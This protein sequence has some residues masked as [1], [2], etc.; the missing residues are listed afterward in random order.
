MMLI[1][2]AFTIT[3]ALS[4]SQ[5]TFAAQDDNLKSGD[6]PAANTALN[7]K[8]ANT[9]DDESLTPILLKKDSNVAAQSKVMDDAKTKRL[10][11]SD[12]EPAEENLPVS[13]NTAQALENAQSVLAK[14]PADTQSDNAVTTTSS[15]AKSVKAWTLDSLNNATWTGDLGKGQFVEYAKIQVLLNRFHSS[16]GVIDGISGTNMI[17]AISAFQVMNNITASGEMDAAT[18]TALN[19]VSSNDVFQSYVVTKEDIDGPYVSGI[20]SDYADQAKM[21]SLAYVRVTEML[22]ER[23]H[24]DENFLKSLNPEATFNKVG[25]N[26][27]VAN[28]RQETTTPV[29]LIIAH[30]GA[31]HLYAFDANNKMI[32]A[33]PATIGSTDT[34][35]PK[36]T[37]QIKAVAPNPWYG[38]SPK[39]FVQGKN[40]K[41]LSLPPGPNNPVGNMWIALSKPS[42]GIH[43]TPNPTL[44]SK[45]ASHGCIR[46]TNWDAGTLSKQVKK[47]VTVKFLE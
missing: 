28:P 41:P 5:P 17:K 3:L 21:K 20:P 18:W 29:A 44:I 27:I 30:K 19:Q 39:N 1:R 11:N 45:T 4:L 25:E 34:P 23:F 12:D 43:G 10:V 13:S 36:G 7:A 40:M 37:Y 42:F 6:L 22:A 15:A 16:P 2:S 32:A 24:M 14:M 46:L 26:L 47:G 9:N 38:Y 8:T 35:S 33:F 31:K